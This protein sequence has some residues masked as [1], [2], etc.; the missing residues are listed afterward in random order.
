MQTN[1]C[2]IRNI[3]YKK[4]NNAIVSCSSYHTEEQDLSQYHING[5]LTLEFQLWQL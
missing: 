2:A 4:I 3:I 5:E 1:Y